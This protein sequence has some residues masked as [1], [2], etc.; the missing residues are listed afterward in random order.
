MACEPEKI[1]DGVTIG[2]VLGPAGYRTLWTGKHHSTENPFDRGFDRYFGLRDGA[3][4]YF[5]PGKV[6]VG[7]PKPA[8]KRSGWAWCIEGQTI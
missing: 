2:E 4:N 5:N 8:R 3:C 6:R 7:E 1:T